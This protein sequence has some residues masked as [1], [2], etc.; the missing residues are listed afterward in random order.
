MT[1][2]V[3]TWKPRAQRLTALALLL[4]VTL[5]VGAVLTAPYLAVSRHYDDRL[6]RLGERLNTYRTI[7]QQGG[8]MRE[9]QR[10]VQ[11]AERT[12]GYY[13]AGDKPALAAAE[14][15]RRVKQVI[16]QHGGTVVSSQVLGEKSAEQGLQQITLRLTLRA[17]IDALTK[18][19]HTL[20]AQPPL[21]VFDNVYIGARPGGTARWRGASVGQEL[22][23][24]IDISGFL[25]HSDPV[26]TAE[27]GG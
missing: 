9:Q 15:Q 23:V 7:V 21:L 12:Q 1:L 16:E 27:R 2:R 6:E 13:L 18:V 20:E 26:D 3:E 19:L 14:L 22:D 24:R 25:R 11:R 5:M 17:G 10:L 8:A 4:G